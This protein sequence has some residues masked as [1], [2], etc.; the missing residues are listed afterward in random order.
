MVHP[1]PGR[2]AVRRA[3]RRPGA[4]DYNG[5]GIEDIAVFRPSTGTW[6]VRNQ[7]TVQ[8]GDRGDV[9]VPGDYNGDGVTDVAV[10]RPSTGDWFVRNQ[11]SVNFGGAGGYVPVAGD[12]NGDGIDDVAVFQPS[13]GM[14]FVRNQFAVAVRRPG[15]PA[16]AGRLQRR[17]RGPISRCIGRRRGSGSCATSSPCSSASPAM[18][19]CRATTTATARR[20]SRSTG[21]RRASGSCKDQFAVQFGD[22]RDI[23]VPLTAA[24]PPAIAGD[25][26]G[27]GAT[28]IAVH[29]PSTNQWFVRNQ[30]AVPFGDPGD[31]PVPADY[32]GD[33]GWTSRCT[34][35]R[36]GTGSCAISR[37]CSSAT[38][39]T[40]RCRATTTATA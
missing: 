11:F 30:L 29:R 34:G 2:R 35:R 6:F 4:G 16:G 21:R 28:D 39:A 24:I 32:N 23:P 25:Y 10:Y 40:S 15:R 27:D 1:E 7:F 13:T 22:G 8:F 38:R 17:R 37:R 19:R 14:W 31:I 3:G 26:D 33:G 36:P 18:S 12:Y 5:D 20:T 9:P